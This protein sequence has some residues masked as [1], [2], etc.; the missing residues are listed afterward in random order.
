VEDADDP[1]QLYLREVAKV[2]PLPPDELAACAQRVRAGDQRAEKDLLEAHL[3]LV[4]TI[5]ERYTSD[6]VHV[7]DLIV[8]GN[9]GLLKALQT[10]RDS[11]EQDF[12]A[13]ATLH[14]EHA[15]RAALE[16]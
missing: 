8:E 12:A 3:A 7:L 11:P 15:I 10:F 6:P 2:V 4:V 9:G 16:S 1:L 13:H 5:A 14:I